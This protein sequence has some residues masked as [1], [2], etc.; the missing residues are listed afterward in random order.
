MW[1]LRLVLYSTLVL[2]FPFASHASTIASCETFGN[3]DISTG[4]NSAACVPANEKFNV[5]FRSENAAARVAYG[6]MGVEGGLQISDGV[7]DGSSGIASGFTSQAMF[8]D[9][10]TV[11]TST[12]TSGFLVFKDL[13]DG[14]SLFAGSGTYGTGA[15]DGNFTD[16]YFIV[17][18][19]I[20]TDT[21]LGNG[22][23]L[24]TV[25]LPFVSSETTSFSFALQTNGGC[26]IGWNSSCQASTD[27][28]NTSIVTGYSVELRYR[29]VGR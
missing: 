10:Y 3:V 16:T 17:S 20:S 14:S 18:G 26:G 27:Y 6:I 23:Q 2:M 28:F 4:A 25:F 9:T 21:T 19:P 7:I 13:V 22:S 1:K 5:G 15:Q 12:P 29:V 24:L 8:S 11:N